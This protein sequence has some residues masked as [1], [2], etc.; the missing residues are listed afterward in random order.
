MN[1]E[2]KD[3]LKILNTGIVWIQQSGTA[4]EAETDTR[5]PFT[6]I[7]IPEIDFVYDTSKLF[8]DGQ[9]VMCYDIIHEEYVTL[10]YVQHE[11]YH[12]VFEYEHSVEILSQQINDIRHASENVPDVDLKVIQNVR[13]GCCLH[14]ESELVWDSY[15]KMQFRSQNMRE[16]FDEIDD[17]LMQGWREWYMSKIREKRQESF[18]ELDHLEK[19]ARENDATPGDLED[20]ETIKQM[21]RDIPQ[22]TDLSQFKRVD[23]MLNFWPSLILPSPF[24]IN[25]KELKNIVVEIDAIDELKV[26]L[27]SVYDLDELVRLVSDLKEL[28]INDKENLPSYVIEEVEN[29]IQKL[30]E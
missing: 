16:I 2:Q 30:R 6:R 12:R 3:L 1:E 19:E 14:T 26:I 13:F 25:F 21:F 15:I 23:E 10:T 5:F 24:T 17:T 20:I 29:R 7:D 4:N 9:S 11:N 8:E 22:E 28:D 27:E 18:L